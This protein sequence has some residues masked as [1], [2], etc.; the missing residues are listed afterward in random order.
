MLT[1]RIHVLLTILLVLTGLGIHASAEPDT[2]VVGG[3]ENGDNDLDARMHRHF[4]RL[5]AVASHKGIRRD[6][7]LG[8]LT[9]EEVMSA[10]INHL[11]SPL[12]LQT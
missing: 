1:T 8:F 2:H 11:H 10:E 3:V 5:Q 7:S 4:R 9:P 6:A 12:A